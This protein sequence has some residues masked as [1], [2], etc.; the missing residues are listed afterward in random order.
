M[1]HLKIKSEYAKYRKELSQ[2]L[3]NGTGSDLSE[4]RLIQGQIK[5]IDRAV[6]IINEQLQKEGQDD[7]D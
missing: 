7:E 5:A 1:D 2:A 6:A 3:E 4:I